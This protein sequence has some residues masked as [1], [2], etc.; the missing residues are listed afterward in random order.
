MREGRCFWREAQSLSS[1]PRGRSRRRAASDM[2]DT[3][4]DADA[5][6]GGVAGGIDG[7]GC[8]GG[9]GTATAVAG[10]VPHVARALHAPSPSGDAVPV[11]R[12][13]EIQPHTF[14]LSVPFPTP[15]EAE[16]AHGSLAPDAEPHRRAVG[17]DLTVS[18]CILAVRWKAEDSH[19]LRISIINFLDQ[20]SLVVQTMQRFGPPVS[21]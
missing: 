8:P 21:R 10:E 11:A 1:P 2:R 15:V 7:H 18:G 17:K 3:D 5:D 14:A 13:P 6:A 4:A 12:K 19:L 20:L 9:G 16:I